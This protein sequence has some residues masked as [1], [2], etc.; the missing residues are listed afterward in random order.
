MKKKLNRILTKELL[1]QRTFQRLVHFLSLKSDFD[2]L[3]VVDDDV[4][5]DA[6]V[7]DDDED[8]GGLDGD[9]DDN[10]K[11]FRSGF[12]GPFRTRIPA[13]TISPLINKGIEGTF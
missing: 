3:D 11:F 2:D 4:D 13:L 8:V 10:D 12:G 5:E 9:G 7:V 6:F 1:K